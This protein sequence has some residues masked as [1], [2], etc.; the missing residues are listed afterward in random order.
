MVAYGKCKC[1]L[2]PDVNG[3]T[4]EIRVVANFGKSF[5]GV[6]RRS[7]KNVVSNVDPSTIK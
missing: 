7:A 5:R 4:Y 6:L 1:G 3:V 2:R